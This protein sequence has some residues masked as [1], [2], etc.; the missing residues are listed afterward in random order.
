MALSYFQY[1]LSFN[2]TTTGFSTLFTNNPAIASLYRKEPIDTENL[3]YNE[4]QA[5]GFRNC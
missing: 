2:L 4:V 1:F 5:L 3:N